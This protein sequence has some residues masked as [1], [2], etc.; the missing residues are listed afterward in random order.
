MPSFVHY[1]LS[2]Q[3]GKLRAL[4]EIVTQYPMLHTDN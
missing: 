2:L 3:G 1:M 4:R